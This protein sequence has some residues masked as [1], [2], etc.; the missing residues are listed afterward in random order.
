MANDGDNL[1]NEK[2]ETT[3][4]WSMAHVIFGLA[5][6]YIMMTLTNWYKYV[7]CAS[8]LL[9]CIYLAVLGLV[10][11]TLFFFVAF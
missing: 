7:S 5:T 4:S 10:D 8:K 6:L 9:P 3:Y 2:E 1:D 11:N